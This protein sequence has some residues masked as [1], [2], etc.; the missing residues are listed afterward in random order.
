MAY[1]FSLRQKVLLIQLTKVYHSSKPQDI[2]NGISVKG[3]IVGPP[4]PISNIRP[5]IFHIPRNETA[6]EKI[7]RH[8]RE[9]VQKWHEEFW[10]NHNT[11]F[12]EERKE[13]EKKLKAAQEGLRCH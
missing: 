6:I 12:I 2:T 13:F 11:K 3:D 8:E 4:N 9:Y 7:F 10:S 5:I 1:T